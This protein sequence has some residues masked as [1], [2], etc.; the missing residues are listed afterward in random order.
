MFDF[1]KGF[2]IN[3]LRPHLK[4]AVQRIAIATSKKTQAIK[5]VRGR[6][7]PSR[8]A[9]DRRFGWGLAH[10]DDC[11]AHQHPSL[12]TLREHRLG[13]R[14][15]AKLLA[16]G[17]EEK[18][19][20]KVEAIIR[21]VLCGSWDVGGC[22]V[23]DFLGG[24]RI[25]RLMLQILRVPQK[26]HVRDD[27]TIEA[28]GIIELMCDLVHERARLLQAE[29]ECPEVRV[30][31]MYIVYGERVLCAD[32]AISIRSRD[33]QDL[34]PAVATL[35][36][37][38]NRADIAELHEVRALHDLPDSDGWTRPHTRTVLNRVLL[39]SRD[40]RAPHR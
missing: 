26:K 28:L 3:S 39:R 36:Y 4:M 22:R 8:A 21:C 40:A 35:I 25:F 15:V 24:Y 7:G 30:W 37:A 5:Y 16:E 29:K 13:Q 17:K 12:S 10:N 33:M 38:A 19:A 23:M 31:G 20:I 27:A 9:V 2:D 32:T 18:A 11:S 6:A 34:K 1:L 14:E